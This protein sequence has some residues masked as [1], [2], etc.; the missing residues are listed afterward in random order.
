MFTTYIQ[1][2]FRTL[3]ISAVSGMLMIVIPLLGLQDINSPDSAFATYSDLEIFIR[4][5]VEMLFPC[6]AGVFL[7]SYSM[8]TMMGLYEIVYDKTMERDLT[9]LEDMAENLLQRGRLK[10]GQ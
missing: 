3:I 9:M 7:F 5:C 4:I 2:D 1:Y 10:Q 8:S 6:M